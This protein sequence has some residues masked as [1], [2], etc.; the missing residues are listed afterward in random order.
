M[1]FCAR[2]WLRHVKLHVIVSKIKDY[3]RR[4]GPESGLDIRLAH[5]QS[6]SSTKLTE[7]SALWEHIAFVHL[8]QSGVRCVEMRVAT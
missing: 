1:H 4:L 2:F 3:L 6:R 7:I 8:P 5:T